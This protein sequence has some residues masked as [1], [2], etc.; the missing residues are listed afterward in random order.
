MITDTVNVAFLQKFEAAQPFSDREAWAVFRLAAISEAVGW[1]LLIAGILTKR[2]IT[3]AS[4]TPVIFA[5]RIHG[6]I[7]L[8]YLLAVALTY[9]SLEWSRKRV[10]V[11]A[12]ASVPPY[13]TLVF[14]QWA[15]YQ[16]RSQALKTYR[17]VTV[18][19]I[20]IKGNNILAIQS[21]DTGYWQLLGGP[22]G[23]NET[24]EEALE[25]LTEE[26]T[27]VVPKL[28]RLVYIRQYRRRSAEQLE[29][30]FHTTNIFAKKDIRQSK[31]L[32]GL[33]YLKPKANPDLEPAFLQS[34]PIIAEAKRPNAST[35][36][37]EQ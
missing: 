6:T 1:T 18:R 13:G 9:S 19:A 11:A 12:V 35:I 10:I 16:R 17:A 22:V 7:F 30:Y 3:P 37:I 5:G 25:R 26:Q 34:R 28:G 20:I 21:K 27:G 4:N 31:N 15:A 23:A 8:C 14:E 33:T 2:Y 29:M 24:A 32:D 36:F